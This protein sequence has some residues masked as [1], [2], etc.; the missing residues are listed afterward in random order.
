MSEN[1]N[2]SSE[3][4]NKKR[5]RTNLS[6][7]NNHKSNSKLISNKFKFGKKT[8]N[9]SAHINVIKPKPVKKIY[10]YNNQAENQY[11]TLDKNYQDEDSEMK[12]DDSVQENSLGQLTKNFINYIKKTGR[13]SININ[14]LVKEL[15][16]KKRRIYDITNV[17]QGINYIQKSGKNEIVWVKT[18]S[19]K[20]KSKKKLSTKKITA[21][22]PK[23]NIEELEKKKNELDKDIDKFKAE[24][25]SIA[26][27][28]DFEKYGYI[29]S[30]DIK[31]LSINANVDI[32]LIKAT[33]GTVMNVIDKSDNQKA[34]DSAKNLMEKK[35]IKSNNSILNLLSKANQLIFTCPDNTEAG[36]NIYEINSGN[37]R[38]IKMN[39]NEINSNN[40]EEN[41]SITKFFDNNNS[42]NNSNNIPQK[43]N[44]NNF[45]AF[46]KQYLFFY[47]NNNHPMMNSNITEKKFPSNTEKGN[48]ET[49]QQPNFT[50]NNKEPNIGISYTSQQQKFSN[51]NY[52]NYN[53]VFNPNNINNNLKEEKFSFTTNNNNLNK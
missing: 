27:K 44:Q 8:K 36:I 50:A 41:I 4:L 23:I 3:I 9:K 37:I 49:F 22:K 6:K 5:T 17:L 30:D 20:S 19:N 16:V 14:D 28:N 29:T 31:R 21:N 32:I 47:N 42:N 53:P 35:E 38:E 15:C 18:I 26:K 48:L 12:K 25:N 1:E 40:D 2:N 43:Q 34:Y 11:N 10:T 7:S 51:F 39:K 13:K 45:T 46:N 52:K 24:F 33:K